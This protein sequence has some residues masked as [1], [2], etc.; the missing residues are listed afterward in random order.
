MNLICLPNMG[1]VQKN[2]VLTSI[3]GKVAGTFLPA[4]CPRH[5]P[6]LLP[7]STTT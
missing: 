4:R 5:N 7:G 6:H 2:E 1:C 3:A